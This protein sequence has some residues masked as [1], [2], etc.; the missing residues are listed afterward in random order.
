MHNCEITKLQSILGKHG[1]SSVAVLG[2]M[3]IVLGNISMTDVKVSGSCLISY[4][5]VFTFIYASS[6]LCKVIAINYYGRL[7]SNL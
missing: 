6:M 2:H 1:I 3:G 5:F 4:L 7:A